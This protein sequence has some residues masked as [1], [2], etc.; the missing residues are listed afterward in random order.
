M[1]QGGDKR[2]EEGEFGFLPAFRSSR[3]SRAVARPAHAQCPVKGW[4]AQQQQRTSVRKPT[5]GSSSSSSSL[6]RAP[7]HQSRPGHHHHRSGPMQDHPSSSP[8]LVEKHL[9]SNVDKR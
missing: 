2:G 5:A 3:H 4:A 8:L 1:G 6:R 7:V 9:I